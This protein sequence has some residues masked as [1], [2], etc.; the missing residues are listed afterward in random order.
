MILGKNVLKGTQFQKNLDT[1]TAFLLTFGS[2]FPLSSCLHNAI[3]GI[4][5]QAK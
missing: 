2:S 5:V 3:P 1:I 4:E